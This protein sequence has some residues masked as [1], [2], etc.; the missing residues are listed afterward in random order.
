MKQI[1]KIIFTLLI[2]C[3]AIISKGQTV[4]YFSHYIEKDHIEKDTLADKN[5]GYKFII[6][7]E[8]IY[9][10]AIDNTGKV[11]WRTD[12]VIDNKIEKYR[13]KRP[14]IVFFAFGPERT[15]EKREVI[16]ISYNNSQ[17]GYLD[18]TSGKFS[19]EGQD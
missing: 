14:V 17:F 1:I 12:P 4:K 5:T 16:F 13:V 10:T 15:K 2:L 18:K 19:F 3:L 9:I 6:D 8:R 11:I 7:K